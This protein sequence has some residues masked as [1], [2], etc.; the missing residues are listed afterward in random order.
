MGNTGTDEARGS[1]YSAA[2]RWVDHALRADDSL[3]TPG[4]TIWSSRWLGE[5][6]NRYLNQPDESSDDFYT[7][8]KR[9]LEGSPAEV[10]QLMAEL[11][12]VHFLIVHQESM[13]GSTKRE[14][15]NRVLG[16]SDKDTA[17]P[18]DLVDGL[19][20]G[21]AN[22]GP[23]F[24]TLRPFQSD[25]LWNVPNDGR[26]AGTK[27]ESNCSTIPGPSSSSCSLSPPANCSRI[28]RAMGPTA[29]QF[30]AL[31][32][33]VFP[34]TFEAILS[35][36]HKK[37]IVSAFATMVTEL[38]DDR[39]HQLAQIRMRLEAEYGTGFNYYH[40]PVLPM[41]NPVETRKAWDKFIG[42]SRIRGIVVWLVGGGVHVR[43][44]PRAA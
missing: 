21:V 29:A 34:D 11:L 32:H 20:V 4:E 8:L 19:S 38:T 15:I 6:R 39:D 7:K 31:L 3:F 18:H 16:W 24:N 33:L 36:A 12:Y 27:I 28:G 41:W 40:D 22:T 25:S 42:P 35:I 1:V 37:Q 10:Y 14:R 30:Q 17:I 9:Q 23:A 43:R 44:S 26:G 13:K 2:S 5:L